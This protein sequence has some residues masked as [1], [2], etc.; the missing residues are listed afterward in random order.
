MHFDAARQKENRQ[1]NL[2]VKR[3]NIKIKKE[4]RNT[5]H[6]ALFL[7]HIA[8]RHHDGL[9]SQFIFIRILRTCPKSKLEFQTRK[10][11]KTGVN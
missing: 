4:N 10:M 5:N 8:K 3:N 6:T 9:L 2:P 7:R 11:C 1:E